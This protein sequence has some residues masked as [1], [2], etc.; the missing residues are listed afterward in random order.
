MHPYVLHFGVIKKHVYEMLMVWENAH[1]KMLGQETVS[2]FWFS[3]QEYKLTIHNQ[4]RK[5]IKN[6]NV[7]VF[8]NNHL[9]VSAYVDLR[10]SVRM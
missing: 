1:N 4:I 2:T 5:A 9:C 3:N 7:R 8:D 10:V 6:K